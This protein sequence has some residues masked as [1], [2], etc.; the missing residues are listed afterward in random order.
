MGEGL[1]REFRHQHGGVQV[2]EK[3]GAEFTGFS[4]CIIYRVM[5]MQ[6]V[7]H[8]RAINAWSINTG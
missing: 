3:V 1:R 4:F 2:E 6:D 5:T 8:I 7:K